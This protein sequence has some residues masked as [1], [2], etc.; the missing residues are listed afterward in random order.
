VTKPGRDWYK[1]NNSTFKIITFLVSIGMP[2]EGVSANQGV[3]RPLENAQPP[4][5][6][7]SVISN[8]FLAGIGYPADVWRCAAVSLKWRAG[9]Y[10]LNVP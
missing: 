4:T 7:G 1:L 9:S 8:Q 3:G 6:R 2:A 5:L 10:V